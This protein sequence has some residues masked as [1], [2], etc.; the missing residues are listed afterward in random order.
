MTTPDSVDEEV[1]G[2]DATQ[3]KSTASRAFGWSFL[4]TIV[5][6][7]GTL[8]IGIA[9]ARLLGP[10]EFGTYAVA[11]VALS[12]VLSFNELGVSLA[13]VRWSGDPREIAPTVNTISVTTSAVLTAAMVLLA[14]QFARA[15]GDESAAPVVQVMSIAVLI[16][17]IVAVP[18][19]LLQRAFQQ[20]R[21]MVVDQ[22]NTWL[23][24]GCSLVLALLGVGA[25]SLA[26]GRIVGASVSAVLFL[27]WSPLP[28]RFGLSRTKLNRCF[29]SAFRWQ[30]RAS[31][32]SPARSPTSWWSRCSWGQPL[33][34]STCWRSIS[35]AGP[36]ASSPN[37][38]AASH[39]LPSQG[40][41]K[42]RRR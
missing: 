17:G 40:C 1:A 19:A 11:L 32:C 12:A 2:G 27:R 21:R 41:R 42:H 3:L 29:A 31:S 22:V 18:A 39:P 25:M 13:I 7:F 15:M 38:S 33:W 34:G 28:F 26:I 14:P 8:A 24:A 6:R 30:G 35:R 5:T 37:P 9:L 20:G 10:E 36:S 4:N 23:G 16:N